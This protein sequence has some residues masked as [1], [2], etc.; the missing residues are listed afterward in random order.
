[1]DESPASNRVSVVAR[2]QENASRNRDQLGIE[3]SNIGRR[4]I[5]TLFDF[6]HECGKQSLD[7]RR[8]GIFL[9]YRYHLRN[10][11]SLLRNHCLQSDAKFCA[12]AF[13]FSWRVVEPPSS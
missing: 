10:S 8:T 9:R 1:M 12:F 3:E 7:F 13:S 4:R 2:D 11:L 6:I 5:V